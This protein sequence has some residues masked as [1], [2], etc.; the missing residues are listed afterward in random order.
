MKLK[1]NDEE[2][3]HYF[4]LSELQKV[5]I[6]AKSRK[7]RI[8]FA[9]LLK[10]LENDGVFP[11]SLF[12]IPEKIVAFVG[13]QLAIDSSFFVTYK[14]GSRSLARDRKRIREIL[15]FREFQKLKPGQA[16]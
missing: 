9:I 3:E 14:R 13:N 7:T 16:S 2:V 11:M 4:T 8:R 10:C 1:W 5:R 15:G 12:P 6:Q